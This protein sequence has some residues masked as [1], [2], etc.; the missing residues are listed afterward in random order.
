MNS[1]LPIPYDKDIVGY[2]SVVVYLS[3]D[4]KLH[5]NHY[6]INKNTSKIIKYFN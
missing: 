1:K 2:L 5:N 3:D 4:Y 6:I